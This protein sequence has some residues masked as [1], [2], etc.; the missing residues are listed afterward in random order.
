MGEG[1]LSG[2][3]LKKKKT[4]KKHIRVIIKESLIISY[5]S[6]ASSAVSFKI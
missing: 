5:I 2:L 1:G 6:C 3:S 4:R